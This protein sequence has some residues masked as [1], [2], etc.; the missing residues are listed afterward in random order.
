MK[1]RHK[2][3]SPDSRG[4]T[5]MSRREILQL[6]IGAAGACVILVSLRPASAHHSF[7]MFDGDKPI[8]LEGVVNEF[9]FTSPHAFILLKV[10]DPNGSVTNW[11]L[12]GAS[13][14]SLARD[15]WTNASLKPGDEVAMKIAPL[16][17][18]APG[19]AWDTKDT[20]FRDGKP[21]AVRK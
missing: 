10:T 18:G 21:V 3:Y 20:T 7:A 8:N 4:M 17:S 2:Q 5:E 15:G 1:K 16:R 6:G 11:S 19:G 14:A 12:E 9:K 13:A